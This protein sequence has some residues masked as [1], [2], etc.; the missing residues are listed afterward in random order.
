AILGVAA[1]IG[2]AL[3]GLLYTESLTALVAVTAIIQAA[4]LIFFAVFLLRRKLP[5]DENPEESTAVNTSED[6]IDND[7]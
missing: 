5:V 6:R 2:G 3:A 1:A 4:A 7:T